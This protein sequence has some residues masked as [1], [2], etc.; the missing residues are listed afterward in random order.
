MPDSP[1]PAALRPPE[2]AA[3]L[4]GLIAASIPTAAKLV[5]CSPSTIRRAIRAGLLHPS[6]KLGRPLISVD[7]LKSF[8]FGPSPTESESQ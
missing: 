4:D 3:S 6:R 1:V 8:L 2:T 5:D 7:E